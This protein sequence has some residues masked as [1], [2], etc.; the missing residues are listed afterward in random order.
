MPSTLASSIAKRFVRN[1]GRSS[2]LPSRTWRSMSAKIS[3]TK[4]LQPSCSPKKLTLL[5]TTGPRSSSTGVSRAVRLAR[6]FRRALVAKTASSATA[7]ALKGCA[8]SSLLRGAMRSNRPTFGSGFGVRGSGSGCSAGSWLRVRGSGSGFWF[9]VLGSRAQNRSKPYKPGTGTQNESPERRTPNPVALGAHALRTGS[10]R[11][12]LRLV[13]RTRL[14]LCGLRLAPLALHVDAATKVRALGNG[15]PGRDDVAVDRPVVADV[16][17]V[18]GGDV[19][20]HFAEHDHG[21]R[22]HLGLDPAVGADRQHMVAQLNGAFDV[23][24]NGQVFAAV[25]LAFD[26][27]RLAYVHD[28]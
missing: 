1:A 26:D 18:T 25:Q 11:L 7:C 16:N 27:D 14:R 20:R 6:N 13:L 5:P 3:S 4:I 8:S 15:N 23:A 12:G 19:P 24:F 17:L 21:L 22:E 10:L 2:S 28:V 9:L